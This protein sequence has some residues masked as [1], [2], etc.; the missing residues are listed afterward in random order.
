[1]IIDSHIHSFRIMKSF[2]N[3]TREEM[4]PMSLFISSTDIR[5]FF[6]MHVEI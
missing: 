6:Q 4:Y 3:G 5:Y 1:M 2:L